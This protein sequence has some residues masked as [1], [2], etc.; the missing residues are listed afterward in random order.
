MTVPRQIGR[1]EIVRRLGSGGFATVW[2]AHDDL[3]DTPVAI[4][5]LADNLVEDTEIRRR[6]LA[7]G[8]FLRKVDSPHLVR[9]HDVGELPDG[10][11]YLVLAYADGGTL[12]DRLR[13]GPLPVGAAVDTILQAAQGISAL[14][15]AGLLH[16]DVKPAN[17]LFHQ[18]PGG[19]RVVVGD[20]GLGKALQEASGIT[21]PSG[22]P[23]Y[24]APEQ[25]RALGLDERAD[26]YSL[27]AVAYAALTGRPPHDFGS[28]EAVLG[29]KSLPEPPSRRAAVPP[30][31]DAVVLRA[32]E[33][34]RDRR[35]PTIDAFATALA[36]VRPTDAITVRPELNHQKKK[37]K[38]AALVAVAAVLAGAGGFAGYQAIRGD[39]ETRVG[40][41]GAAVSV[42][43]PGDW[44]SDVR[45]SQWTPGGGEPKPTLVA[46][47]QSDRFSAADS[48][49]PGVFLGVLPKDA[50]PNSLT[51]HPECQQAGQLNQPTAE[52]PRITQEFAGCPGGTSIVEAVVDLGDLLA[53]V[54]VRSTTIEQGRAV[55]DSTRKGS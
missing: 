45:T 3:L 13:S 15:R 25:V 22:T 7:E 24:V 17:L 47:A 29:L 43:V 11:P 10:R 26:V 42:L 14:H 37:L 32:L 55:V 39:R 38:L 4:K 5:V 30:E 34:D 48:S 46:S 52:K 51:A 41:D 27:G 36:Q 20:L 2:L 31:Y 18:E 16:R 1:F 28:L 19:Y 50:L 35:W 12:A 23:T 21:I 54:Q 53:R 6:F 44:A 40:T 9:V 33:P 49:Q 8:R